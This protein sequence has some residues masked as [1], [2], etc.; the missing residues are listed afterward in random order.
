MTEIQSW[1]PGY[2]EAVDVS[3]QTKELPGASIKLAGKNDVLVVPRPLSSHEFEWAV[4]GIELKVPKEFKEQA[5]RQAQAEF[6]LFASRSR[7]PF[8]QVVTDLN[9]G[10]VMYYHSAVTR[11]GEKIVEER[12]FL[13]M[14]DL[15]AYMGR[16]CH[17]MGADIG[18]REDDGVT[19]IAPS[20]LPEPKRARFAVE[21]FNPD[22]K[23]V[24]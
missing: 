20:E 21:D 12:A 7:L 6:L 9:R 1:L 15:K 3:G 23:S 2:L 14:E 19:P 4:L 18:G 13:C 8:V 17:N 16:M 11:E 22:R 24:V 5:L 10:A